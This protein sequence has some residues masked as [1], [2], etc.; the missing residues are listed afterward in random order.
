ME[1]LRGDLNIL[2]STYARTVD[3]DPIYFAHQYTNPKDRELIAF[4]AAMYAFGN[5]KA[6]FRTLE[7]IVSFLGNQPY[8]KILRT[9]LE[10]LKKYPFSKHRWIKPSDT[11]I[12][13]LL[14]QR[15]LNE[16]GSLEKSF[17]IFL[18]NSDF[19][20]AM[21]HWM[22]FLKQSLVDLQEKKPTL[23]QKFLLSSPKN[24]SASK[25]LMMF[26]RWI[27][28]D[29]FPD[30][31]LWKSIVKSDLFIPLDHHLY[32]FSSHLGF[33]KSKQ[34]NWKTVVE[35]TKRFREIDKEDPIRYDFSL[36]QLGIRKFCIHKADSKYCEPCVI[37]S[38]CKLYKKLKL[39]RNSPK[40]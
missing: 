28:R 35:I 16:Y 17:S 26:F 10:E 15:I 19:E 40:K 7:N 31:G 6:I 23:G 33:T 22:E 12:F 32:E 1:L 37:N 30:L 36:A 4:I 3:S 9:S 8:E 21:S 39:L 24:K 5:V 13:L 27:V 34:A 29:E 11:R 38:H 25:R 2:H 14:L 18:N 20:S